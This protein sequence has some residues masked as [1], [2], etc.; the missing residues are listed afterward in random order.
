M[1]WDSVLIELLISRGRYYYPDILAPIYQPSDWRN[2]V[3]DS[4][5]EYLYD[6]SFNGTNGRRLAW[7]SGGRQL[8]NQRVPGGGGAAGVEQCQQ[9]CLGQP[10]CRGFFLGAA[11]DCHTVN[12]TNVAVATGLAGVSYRRKRIGLPLVPNLTRAVWIDVTVPATTA[13][14]LYTGSVAVLQL[15]TEGRGQAHAQ[16]QEESTDTQGQ[17]QLLFSVPIS[18]RVWRIHPDCLATQLGLYGKAYGF[19]PMTVGQ[20]Y[21]PPPPT[22]VR[23]TADGNLT[24]H[25]RV[26][27]LSRS[28]GPALP[29]AIQTFTD[30]MCERHVPAEAL[31][32]SWATQRPLSDIEL[33]L[34]NSGA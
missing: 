34:D 30:F 22:P 27:P 32:N 28:T 17:Q 33:L 7:E 20:L 25:S 15:A 1:Y 11:G 26:A 6:G 2:V 18:L 13:P 5:F 31:A 24:R 14:G 16:G 21:P 3:K 12:A 19:D 10:A 8:S 9:I 23:V 4:V 29:K